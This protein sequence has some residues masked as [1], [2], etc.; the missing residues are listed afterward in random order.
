MREITLFSYKKI[1]MDKLKKSLKLQGL[2][3]KFSIKY[4]NPIIKSK[5]DIHNLIDE[6]YKSDIFVIG[7]DGE[8]DTGYWHVTSIIISLAGLD[9][10][11]HDFHR[12]GYFVYFKK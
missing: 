4:Y 2:I 5:N 10:R 12:D 3:G 8:K 7:E 6:F 11:I 1:D 9:N